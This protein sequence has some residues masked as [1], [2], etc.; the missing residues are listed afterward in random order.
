[1]EEQPLEAGVTY[2][3]RR[4]FA[5]VVAFQDLVGEPVAAAAVARGRL[6]WLQRQSRFGTERPPYAYQTGYL[7]TARVGIF[8]LLQAGIYYHRSRKYVSTVVLT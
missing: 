7:P 8:L 5:F 4:H 3:V 1:M 2:L 6:S